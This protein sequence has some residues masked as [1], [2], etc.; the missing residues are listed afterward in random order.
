MA[1]D[2]RS[3]WKRHYLIAEEYK[4]CAPAKW[5]GTPVRDG[6][7]SCSSS[8]ASFSQ[9]LNGL[10]R[11]FGMETLLNG[12]CPSSIWLAKWPGTPVRDGNLEYG[13]KPNSIHISGAKWPG[14]PVRD[15]N[16]RKLRSGANTIGRLNGLGRPFG[17]D[18]PFV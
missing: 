16:N 3:G 2:A 18:T 7:N 8:V 12:G 9:R 4:D 5:P 13:Q 14:T 15:G 1:W 10:G 6:N 11:P 17:M